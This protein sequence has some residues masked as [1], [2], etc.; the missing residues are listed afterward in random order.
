MV[1][2][3]KAFLTLARR[4]V[5]DICDRFVLA[6]SR[7]GASG[8]HKAALAAYYSQDYYTEFSRDVLKKSTEELLAVPVPATLKSGVEIF[9]QL[10]TNAKDCDRARVVVASHRA[11]IRIDSKLV[12]LEIWNFYRQIG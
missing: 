7:T 9:R 12:R 6:A 3:S 8:E 10:P 2:T 11:N 5:L 1:G 4:A